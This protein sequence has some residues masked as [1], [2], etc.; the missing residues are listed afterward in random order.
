[1]TRR[2]KRRDRCPAHLALGCLEAALFGS[3]VMSDVSPEWDRR[4]TCGVNAHKR[5][6]RPYCAAI[7]I[8][9]DRNASWLDRVGTPGFKHVD[10]QKAERA[11]R[12]TI[13]KDGVWNIGPILQGFA[14][15]IP[16]RIIAAISGLGNTF[17]D[18][19]RA[20]NGMPVKRSFATGWIGHLNHHKF[21]IIAGQCK[22]FENLTRD[23]RKPGLLGAGLTVATSTHGMPS[24]IER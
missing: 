18:V 15:S 14:C 23:T 19:D 1:M 16:S 20:P 6:K 4:R 2:L 3:A 8:H 12:V 5:P 13:A 7:G 22:T 10:G 24:L 9:T 21:P 17:N 11:F